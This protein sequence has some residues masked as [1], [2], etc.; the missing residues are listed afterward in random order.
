[1][2]ERQIEFNPS[3]D[4]LSTQ[5]LVHWSLCELHWYNRPQPPRLP[6][7]S[8]HRR[9]HYRRINPF[10]G[11]NNINYQPLSNSNELL[12]FQTSLLIGT[13]EA[14]PLN[15]EESAILTSPME[16]RSLVSG[17]M[18]PTSPTISNSQSTT[19]STSSS[20]GMTQ[21]RREVLL[22]HQDQRRRD[23]LNERI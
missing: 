23:E 20:L 12:P 21:I 9:L 17:I 10:R 7:R 2:S 16:R 1:M 13:E 3:I 8:N 15:E 5:R 11:G 19:A 4:P 6:Y 14:T 22:H 18:S